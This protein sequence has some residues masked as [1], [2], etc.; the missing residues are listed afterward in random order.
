MKD[1]FEYQPEF[2]FGC[3]VK[4]RKIIERR[5]IPQWD[6]VYANYLTKTKEWNLSDESSKKA[7]LLFTKEWVDAH[8]FTA[9]SASLIIPKRTKLS[10]PVLDDGEN[11]TE[12]R[13][14]DNIVQSIEEPIVL[15]TEET[16][17]LPIETENTEK[18]KERKEEEVI[19]IAPPILELEEEEKFRDVNG[20]IIDIEVRGERNENNIYF[21]CKD[22]SSGFEI[23]NLNKNI[24]Q[25][26]S[27]YNRENDYTFFIRSLIEGANKKQPTLYLTYE[28]LLRVLF[29]SRNKNT[30]IFR[31]WATNK[32]FTIQM[33]TKEEKEVLGADLLNINLKNIR[34]V[35]NKFSQSFSCIYL[36]SL[37]KVGQLRETFGIS[38]DIDDSLTVYKYGRTK[39][40]NNRLG[41]HIND[42]GKLPNVNLEPV[43][44]KYIDLKYTVEAERYI[45]NFFDS[46]GK[47]L[48]VEGRTELVTLNLKE[49]DVIKEV[50]T[51]AGRNYAGATQALQEEIAKLNTD[52]TKLNTDITKLNADITELKLKH[53]LELQEERSDKEKYKTR[54]ETAELISSLKEEHYKQMQSMFEKIKN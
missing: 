49:F 21:R 24:T 12:A 19:E 11:I 39:D 23:N 43:L 31:K 18:P 30:T 42:Y 44:F 51:T 46:F 33:G 38:A 28:G 22:V 34:A 13:T 6:Y 16:V 53:Q 32:L 9:S 5:N 27:G 3:T 48:K 20:N 17:I 41:K 47:A 52:I 36:I 10:R 35:F 54:S 26:H 29:V 15:S 25:P 50:Y 2:F 1:L 4:K 14:E 37:G 40:F 7:Q 8:F 45:R